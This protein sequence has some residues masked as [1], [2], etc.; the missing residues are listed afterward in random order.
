[1]TSVVH[2]RFSDITFTLPWSGISETILT[3]AFFINHLDQL[4]NGD[5]RSS[6]NQTIIH[7]LH[8]HPATQNT[9]SKRRLQSREKLLTRRKNRNT[10]RKLKGQ[11]RNQNRSHL[12]RVFCSSNVSTATWFDEHALPGEPPLITEICSSYKMLKSRPPVMRVVF[13]FGRSALNSLK[14]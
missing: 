11:R 9:L 5:H 2:A 3:G 1:M 12:C 13:C 8:I 10:P 14:R 7:F 6:Q 4:Y